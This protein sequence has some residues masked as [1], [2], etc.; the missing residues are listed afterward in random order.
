MNNENEKDLK[1]TNGGSPLTP[2]GTSSDLAEFSLRNLFAKVDPEG[3]TNYDKMM[4]QYNEKVRAEA[5]KYMNP[6]R[7]DLRDTLEPFA[8]RASDNIAA[9]TPVLSQYG[10]TICS[11]GNISAV[12][13]DAKSK[14]TFLCTA[15]VGAM[16]NPST[17]VRPM[18]IAHNYRRVLWVDTEQSVEHIQRVLYRINLLTNND[19]Q[20]EHQMLYA[21]ALREVDPLRRKKLVEDALEYYK[22]KLVIIDGISDLMYNTNA[23]DESEALVSKLLALSTQYECHIMVVLHTNPDSDK[24][25]GHIGS[26]LRRKVE[27]MMFVHRV[28]DV[29]VVEPRV[30]RN[31]EF[32]RFAFHIEE[33]DADTVSRYPAAE[34]LGLPVQCPL[35]HDASEKEDDCVKV[36]REELGG[37]AHRNLLCSKLTTIYGI[38]EN[39][40]RVKIS[41]AVSKG[42][43]LC[44]NENILSLP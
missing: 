35:P 29:S 2:R 36:L 12:V 9:L 18:G 30:C 7:R 13:G 42:L 1:Q 39:Y 15:I 40:A 31:S 20:S 28:G 23:P 41:R 22:P 33:V 3:T 11:E 26:T 8:C 17:L 5:D 32:E 24:A 27:A 43:M 16:L 10:M 19:L 6:R 34:G 14:K 25:R 21:L 44:D 4:S 37:V 38:T